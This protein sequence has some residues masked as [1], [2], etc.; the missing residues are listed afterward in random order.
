[1][2]K[3]ALGLAGGVLELAQALGLAGDALGWQEEVLGSG[4]GN[5]GIQ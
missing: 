2:G 4:G 1:M 5:S 3:K